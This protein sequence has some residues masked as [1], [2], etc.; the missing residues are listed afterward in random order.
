VCKSFKEGISNDFPLNGVTETVFFISVLFL[1][2]FDF[3]VETLENAC[4]I[5]RIINLINKNVST[6]MIR[7]V[8]K[9]PIQL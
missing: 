3:F 6:D 9:P 1:I 8:I 5:L 7:K 2:G 4:L